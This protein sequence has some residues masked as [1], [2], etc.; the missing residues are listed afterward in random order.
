[1]SKIIY[2]IQQVGVG[3]SNLFESWKWYKEYFGF[4]IRIFEDN[5][6]AELMLPYTGGKPQQRHAA[7]AMN[8]Q[9]GGGMEIWQYKG[10]TPLKPEH[11]VSIGDLGIFAAKIKSPNVAKAH[12]TLSSKGVN[13]SK[14]YNT[15]DGKLHFFV[16]DPFG[17]TFEIIDDAA[18]F[19]N[20]NKF[21]SG[22]AGAIVGVSDIE[23]SL[24][25]YRDI[26]GYNQVIYDTQ[27]EQQDFKTL[28]QGNGNFRR[29][30]LSHSDKRVG[31]FAEFFAKSYIELVQPLDRKPEK[32]FSNRF[33][34]DLGFIHLC[35]DVKGM[36]DLEKE[37]KDLGFNFTVNSNVKH[38][39]QGSFDMGEAAGHFT[40]IEDPD[41]TL[42]EF[43]EAH[44][45]PL[46]KSLGIQL[47]L[48]KRNPNKPLPRWIIKLL[49]LKRVKDF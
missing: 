15:P 2:G 8:M 31:G 38:N 33:W 44:R 9:G 40:Y 26:L 3:V 30:L 35:Y 7:L 21:I 23:K 45:L 39:E 16:F 42:I 20:E 14:L 29:V 24:K 41:G 49:R 48:D 36:S 6:V 43:V 19:K 22:I 47:N 34:G 32:I 4:D 10:R 5:T 18:V 25:V 12:Q 11:P 46:V 1:M 37:C 17:N 27:G 13:V 28:P